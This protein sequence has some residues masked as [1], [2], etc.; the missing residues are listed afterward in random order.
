MNAWVAA[1]QAA[2]FLSL[3]SEFPSKSPSWLS[4]SSLSLLPPPVS[5]SPSFSSAILEEWSAINR[6]NF[7]P[8]SSS[9]VNGV[10]KAHLEPHEAKYT[11]VKRGHV[12]FFKSSLFIQNFPMQPWQSFFLNFFKMKKKHLHEFEI[13]QILKLYHAFFRLVRYWFAPVLLLFSYYMQHSLLIVL[14]VSSLWDYFGGF[15]K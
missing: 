13:S 11:Q 2:L 1:T 12:S 4:C 5:D 9:L 15:I 10:D 8:A 7:P 14:P 3:S 6:S